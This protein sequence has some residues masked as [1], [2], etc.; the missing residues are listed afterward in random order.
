M[1]T[2]DERVEMVS[3]YFKNNDC[4][5]AASRLF[6]ELH[7]NKN[8]SHTYI[9]KLM[10]KFR[11]T[12]SVAN[13]K[14]EP[15]Q[16]QRNE[17]MQVAV[18]GH[19]EMDSTISTRQL[20]ET[21]GISRTTIQRI[22]KMN[23][24]HPYK[25]QLIQELNDDDNDRRLEFCETMSALIARNPDFTFN[26]CF[27]DEC[28]FFLNGM[29]NRH[30]CRFWSD[31][32]P[33]IF[34]EIH[35][36]YPQKLNVWAGIYG[37]NIVGPFFLNATLNGE[38]Y[39]NLLQNAIDP[40]LTR[41]LENNQEYQEDALYFQQ[42]GAPPHHALPVR[43]YLHNTFPN[44]WIGRRGPIE[45][46]AR[47]PDLSPLDFFLWGHLKSLIYKTDVPNLDA[48]R[49]RI[50]EECGRITPETLRSVRRTFEQRLYYCMEAGG[51]HFEHLI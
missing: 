25:I 47:S 28:S 20:A 5:R 44:R 33:R 18:L 12:G 38:L 9:C 2:I 7:R 1:Y 34:R 46:P 43:Q 39:L 31:T 45:W 41:I 21:S 15:E 30:N 42:D 26:T 8:V 27:S 51:G 48:L 3:L 35:T 49:Q 19:I 50:V 14:H 23:K 4:A 17:A 24:Y 10:Q 32:N 29:I 11:E 16:R 13:K 40:E 37:D 22:L 6:N 36:Q